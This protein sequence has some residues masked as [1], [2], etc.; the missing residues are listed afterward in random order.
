MSGADLCLTKENKA[1][2]CEEAIEQGQGLDLDPGACQARCLEEVE[3]ITSKC[4]IFTPFFRKNVS[5][6]DQNQQI[7]AT[8]VTS[9]A[10]DQ[11]KKLLKEV[12]AEYVPKL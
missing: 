7:P 12:Q 6:L 4:M 1:W 9:A 5:F 11:S 8:L 10:K 3:L 2:N